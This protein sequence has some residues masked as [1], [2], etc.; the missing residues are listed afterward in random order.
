MTNNYIVNR[1]ATLKARL[2]KME[3]QLLTDISAKRKKTINRKIWKYKKEL[4]N[5]FLQ[6]Y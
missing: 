5:L 4:D 6:N 3:K 2:K 1:K